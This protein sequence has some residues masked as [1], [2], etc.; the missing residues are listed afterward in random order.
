MD[1][2]RTKSEYKSY[3]EN[4]RQEK[5]QKNKEVQKQSFTI[6]DVTVYP[7]KDKK[8]FDWEY[9]YNKE[10]PQGTAEEVK[11]W[12]EDRKE[13]MKYAKLNSWKIYNQTITKSMEIIE[14][15][16]KGSPIGTEKTW[17]ERRMKKNQLQN[18]L[19]QKFWLNKLHLQ[20]MNN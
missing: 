20:Q 1:F 2:N 11:K 10:K 6:G 18:N 15:A 7:Q 8:S 3:L 9:V 17:E 13:A 12:K 19:L 14:K 16:K 5:A 4:K